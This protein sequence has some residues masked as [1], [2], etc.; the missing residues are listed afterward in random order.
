M[1]IFGKNGQI[2]PKLQINDISS[3]IRDEGFASPDA[4]HRPGVPATR[5]VCAESQGHLQTFHVPGMFGLILT[6]G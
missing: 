4:D 5:T 3:Q 2:T 1:T 6:F